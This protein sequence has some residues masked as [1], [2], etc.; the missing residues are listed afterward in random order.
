MASGDLD[1]DGDADVIISQTNGAPIILR[2]NGT[3]NHWLGIDLRG[4][5]KSAPNG[6]GAR[7]VVTEANGRK[8]FFNQSNSGSYLAAHDSRLLVGLGNEASVTQIEIR[9]T[10]G[11][12]QTLEN[13][14]I[15]RYHLIKEK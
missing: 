13:P 15:D 7:I 2:N 14:S 5:A 11:K 1:N 10:S 12:I 9:W 8:Q 6:E 3:K 4:G